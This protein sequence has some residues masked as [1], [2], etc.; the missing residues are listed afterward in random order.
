MAAGDGLVNEIV[1]PIAV[2]Q[3]VAMIDGLNAANDAMSTLIGTA[4]QLSA[5]LKG[6]TNISSFNENLISAESNANK[7]DETL[8]EQIST[9]NQL[10]AATQQYSQST[11][12]V[13]TNASAARG[14]IKSL[15]RELQTLQEIQ[16]KASPNGKAYQ[17]LATQIANVKNRI[18]ELSPALQNTNVQVNTVN[19]SFTVM[20]VN[21]E[22]V[23]ARM[24]VRM[25]AMQLIFT[26][27]IAGITLFVEWINKLSN[28]EEQAKDRL[29]AYNNSL[30]EFN[31][32]QSE[33]PANLKS[34][35]FIGGQNSDNL[36]HIMNDQTQSIEAR[37][38]AYNKLIG[39]MPGLFHGLTQEE[40]LTGKGTDAINDRAIAINKLQNELKENIRLRD[41]AQKTIAAK[42]N[43]E[44]ESERLYD[45]TGQGNDPMSKSKRAELNALINKSI[46]YNNAAGQNQQDLARINS[47]EIKPK[48]IRGRG[49]INAQNAPKLTGD[50]D[51]QK[52]QIE[53][54]RDTQKEIAENE[55]NSLNIRLEAN[56]KYYNTLIQLANLEK[57]KKNENNQTTIDNALQKE[58]ELR[59]KLSQVQNDSIKFKPGEKNI[60]IT[61]LN[62]NIAIQEAI[63]KDAN[64]KNLANNIAFYNETKN[65]A[66]QEGKAIINIRSKDEDK[67]LDKQKQDFAFQEVGV[68]EAY[69]AQELA[70]KESLD[71]KKIT[72]D[73]YNAHFEALEK[74]LN[75]TI[76]ADAQKFLE[77]LIKSGRLTVEQLLEVK[78]QLGDLNGDKTKDTGSDKDKSIRPTDPIA[79]I[80]TPAKT[81]GETEQDYQDRLLAAKESFWEKSTELAAAS[82]NAINT[83][84]N[85]AF[86]AEQ[87][88][89]Q[90][91]MTEL[92]NANQIQIQGINATTGYQITKDN[93]LS[94]QNAKF[95]SQQNTIQQEQNQIA[96]KKAKAD[97]TAAESS[98]VANTGV[99]IVKALSLLADPLTIPLGIAEIALITAT[100]AVQFAAASSTPLPQFRY[101][102]P[103]GGT[104]TPLFIAGEANENEWIQPKGKSGYWSGDKA[105]VFNEPLGTSVTPMHKIMEYAN[106]HITGMVDFE[107]NKDSSA[108]ELAEM[109]GDK[110]EKSNSDV[111]YALIRS[112]NPS[113]IVQNNN[114][115]DNLTWKIGRK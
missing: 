100:G 4:T 38:D 61:N 5:A 103:I 20:G 97:K 113:I 2:E 78:R 106:T 26:P 63:I 87:Q 82:Y 36:L 53:F 33:S 96:L 62:K 18:N 13:A 111:V 85:N 56:H 79:S 14:E 115:S 91:K 83:I 67:W 109:I 16:A 80:L 46:Q 11:I 98:I 60:E 105:S 9:T 72:H 41:E 44:S 1:D 10:N 32:L 48:N 49:G 7:L 35:T 88:Q 29:D 31:K 28:A 57:Q 30:K 50:A 6:S 108:R 75:A 65:L 40:V 104:T 68:R 99:A 12:S 55:Q 17:E 52:Q 70:L 107:G 45:I 22:S 77:G 64:K 102:T 69:V 71:K 66:N 114:R 76:N 81:D 34:G 73:Q 84:R 89:L 47:P 92:Q 59:H 43:S 24:G 74:Q 51:Y 39:I 27:I 112:R 110:I 101:G 21:A 15:T 37:T 58:V 95:A 86:A 25:V 93:Q 54:E 3:V 42:R 94:A 90:I 19:K 23:L 8:N